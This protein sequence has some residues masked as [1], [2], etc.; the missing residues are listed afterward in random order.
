MSSTTKRSIARD[1]NISDINTS[2]RYRDTHSSSDQESGGDSKKKRGRPSKQS[3]LSKHL[4][5]LVDYIKEN[6][7]P[8]T[9]NN[10]VKI[11][12]V[13]TQLDDKSLQSLFQD[14]KNNAKMS[15]T[16]D[17]NQNSVEDELENEMLLMMKQGFFT[18][19]PTHSVRNK[20]D[21]KNL[22]LKEYYSTGLDSKELKDSYKNA[23][24]DVRE[25][26]ANKEVYSAKSSEG[27]S[28]ILYYKDP[29]LLMNVDRDLMDMWNEVGKKIPQQNINLE[30]ALNQCGQK[31]LEAVEWLNE[32]KK[33]V[34]EDNKK[35]KR[36]SKRR[37]ITNSHL[38]SA[39]N[40]K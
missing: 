40:V 38:P 6:E 1:L 32:R 4:K 28:F 20:N 18:Y 9:F 19:Q 12:E 23:E 27:K 10:L 13:D 7:K 24:E 33:K 3:I 37:K 34:Q 35:T 29:T 25:L 31:P 39:E 15:F 21:I 2:T 14:L 8:I 26:I 17:R 5:T 16:W 36:K 30:G 11:T 22:L